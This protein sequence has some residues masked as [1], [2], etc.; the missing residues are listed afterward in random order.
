MFI[1]LDVLRVGAT[2]AAKLQCN[3]A[4]AM[5]G[6]AHVFATRIERLAKHQDAFP[7]WVRIVVAAGR[8]CA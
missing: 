3:H 6:S 5:P 2:L 1:Q 7:M 4:R 8:I